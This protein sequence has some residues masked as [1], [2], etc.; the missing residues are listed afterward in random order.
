MPTGAKV[1]ENRL[2][3]VAERRGLSLEKNRRRDQKAVDY[4]LFRLDPKEPWAALEEI[5][6]RL[7]C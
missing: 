1:L 6:R 7:E 4:G 5:K 2:R 3:R